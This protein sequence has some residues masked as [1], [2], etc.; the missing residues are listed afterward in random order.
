[1]ENRSSITYKSV[2]RK[3]FDTRDWR[4]TP[5]VAPPDPPTPIITEII[6]VFIFKESAIL[7]AIDSD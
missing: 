3:I 4:R 6:I 5:P 2:D 7:L 1:M